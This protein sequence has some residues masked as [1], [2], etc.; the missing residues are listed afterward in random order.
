LVSQGRQVAIRADDD[1]VASSRARELERLLGRK[2]MEK[3]TESNGISE[4]VK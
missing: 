2:A 1:V 3:S 4:A